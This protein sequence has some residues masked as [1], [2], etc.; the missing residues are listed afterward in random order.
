MCSPNEE[1]TLIGTH[2]RD[3]EGFVYHNPG[4]ECNGEIVQI[5]GRARDERLEPDIPHFF[6]RFSN[7]V[8]GLSSYQKLSPWFDIQVVRQR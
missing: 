2:A 4:H 1:I 8:V 5:V 3:V 6:I 7:S